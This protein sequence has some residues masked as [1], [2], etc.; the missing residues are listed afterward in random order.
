[1]TATTRTAYASKTHTYRGHEICPVQYA[2][3]AGQGYRWYVQS[4]HQTGIA[5]GSDCCTHYYTLAAAKTAI[6][7]SIRYAEYE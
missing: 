1:M 2:D 3:K 5:Y 6:D 4:Y 7:E